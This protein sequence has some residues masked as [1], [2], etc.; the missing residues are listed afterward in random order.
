MFQIGCILNKYRL[1]LRSF[2]KDLPMER[3]DILRF[4]FSFHLFEV[5]TRIL[6]FLPNIIL[7][8][9]TWIW[10]TQ[11]DQKKLVRHM[12][13]PSY[14]YDEY[15]ISIGLGPS[16][17]SV[18]YAKKRRTVVRHIQ[19]HLYILDTPFLSKDKTTFKYELTGS[20]GLC[21]GKFLCSR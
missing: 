19:V 7:Y 15:L 1:L 6:L 17:S 5:S 10:Q 2:Y 14:T 8:R 3:E 13:N 12:Q 11:W 16:I 21:I 4:I 20:I 9:W 18:I